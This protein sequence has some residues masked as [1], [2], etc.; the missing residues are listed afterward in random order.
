V[1]NVTCSRDPLA[2]P[3]PPAWQDPCCGS[4]HPVSLQNTALLNIVLILITVVA[5]W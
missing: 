1:R 4:Y 3:W 2:S 5:L